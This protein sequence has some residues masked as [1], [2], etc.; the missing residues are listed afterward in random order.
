MNFRYHIIIA[1]LFL[2]V[3]LW[4]S[5]N[6]NLT[7]DIDYEV[8]VKLNVSKPYAI[9]NIVPRF[10]SVK[11]KGHGWSHLRLYTSSMLEFNYDI[12]PK[13]GNQH[14]ILTQEYLNERFD[15]S[16]NLRVTSIYP[17]TLIVN[18]GTYAEKYVKLQPEAIVECREGYQVVGRPMLEPDSIKI[19]GAFNLL[20][21]INSLPTAV[22]HFQNVNSSITQ[23]V[24]VTDSLSNILWKSQDEV[25]MKITVELSAS[26]ELNDI[27]LKVS[28]LPPDKDVLLIPQNLSLQVRGGVNQLAGLD[29]SSIQA[30][31]EYA[32]L[33]SD[34]TGAVM[35][36]FRL[37]EGI[38]IISTKP[39]KVQYIIKKKY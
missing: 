31:V 22:V 9:S 8:P 6:L 28:N 27:E 14:L 24:K 21:A 12:D 13:K 17:E 38:K 15:L 5:L 23:T 39:E 26:K 25:L 16:G 4:T 20:Q 35:P 36:K 29:N 1:S 7:Y 37:P 18:L 2:S 33:L 19:G 11:L 32:Q 30:S 3:L 34:T 10:L